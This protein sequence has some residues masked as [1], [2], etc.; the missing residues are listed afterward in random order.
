MLAEREPVTPVSF[1]CRTWGTF[2][3][4]RARQS[5]A[6]CDARSWGKRSS[7]LG[8]QRWARPSVLRHARR[9]GLYRCHVHH[10]HLYFHDL[11]PFCFL[12]LYVT[13]RLDWGILRS[14]PSCC[15]YALL[16]PALASLRT[17]RP[18]TPFR[19]PTAGVPGLS[20]GLTT[21]DKGRRKQLVDG[22]AVAVRTSDGSVCSHQRFERCVAV[23]ASIFV[24]WHFFSPYCPLSFCLPDR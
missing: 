9:P 24:N 17:G 23:V 12:L 13:A 8:R 2:G 22:R 20:G 14:Q 5:R 19:P 18:F 10:R 4:S 1:V 15:F 3:C 6:V 7:R 21:G 11:D 16:M